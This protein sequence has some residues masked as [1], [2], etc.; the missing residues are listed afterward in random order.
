MGG[1]SFRRLG[2]TKTVTF[3][4]LVPPVAFSHGLAGPQGHR[5]RVVR[6]PVERLARLAGTEQSLQPAV[7]G[8]PCLS[9]QQPAKDRALST[10]HE[11][12]L[13]VD[14]SPVVPADEATAPANA[15]IAP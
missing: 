1:V 14:P 15:A 3:V 7:G 12:E 11:S 4:L 10:K 6:C 8:E 5:R 2:H 13:G 9:A